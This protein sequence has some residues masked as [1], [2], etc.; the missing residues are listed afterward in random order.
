MMDG[1]KK[2]R[3][4]S[5][6]RGPLLSQLCSAGKYRNSHSPPPP[7]PMGSPLDYPPA[8]HWHLD[9][10]PVSFHVP[11]LGH[12]RVLAKNDNHSHAIYLS[13]CITTEPLSAAFDCSSF[14]MHKTTVPVDD[15][16]TL[17]QKCMNFSYLFR[18]SHIK[19]ECGIQIGKDGFPKK[20]N[21]VNRA[22]YLHTIAT[23]NFGLSST[24]PRQTHQAH[25]R[26]SPAVF[27]VRSVQSINK[28]GV[29]VVGQDLCCDQTQLIKSVKFPQKGVKKQNINHRFTI[30][31]GVVNWTRPDL[32]DAFVGRLEV[33]YHPPWYLYVDYLRYDKYYYSCPPAKLGIGNILK[34]LLRRAHYL[35]TYLVVNL[36][37]PPGPISSWQF[38]SFCSAS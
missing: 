9:W 30:G 21:K 27:L 5:G 17:F 14:P 13:P 24:P 6:E 32:S 11:D 1:W 29:N 8:N 22:R 23:F 20:T 31:L 10:R 7:P 26:H 19:P 36:I 37:G 34:Q 35:T 18:N 28:Y 4:E 33:A 3:R 2:K 16:W 25:N 38:C 12:H 15:H